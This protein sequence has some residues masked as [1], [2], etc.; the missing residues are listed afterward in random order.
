MVCFLSLQ[1]ILSQK[2]KENLIVHAKWLE[3]GELEAVL[4]NR[5]LVVLRFGTTCSGTF[6]NSVQRM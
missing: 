1:T 2:I 6:S 5:S 4:I 3:N